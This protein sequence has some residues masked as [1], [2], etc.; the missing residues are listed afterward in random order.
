MKKGKLS[1]QAELTIQF[2]ALHLIRLALEIPIFSVLPIGVK[3]FHFIP[4]AAKALAKVN[5][6]SASIRSI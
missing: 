2:M 6:H 3:R 5:E 4:L 1:D